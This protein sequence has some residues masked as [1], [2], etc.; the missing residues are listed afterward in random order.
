SG[1]G[2][3]GSALNRFGSPWRVLC[4]AL[5][6]GLFALAGRVE[7]RAIPAHTGRVQDEAGLLSPVLRQRV[8]AWLLAYQQQTGHQLEL[9]TVHSLEG[10]VLEDFTIRVVE[11]WKLGNQ[12]RDDGLL[13][14]VAE[15]EHQIRIE[16]SHGLEG[17]LTDVVS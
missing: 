7:A 3:R 12:E 8:S 13:L 1:E 9:L 15:A 6:V 4:A 14:F 2:P 5:L 17:D 11:A 16:V 10:D